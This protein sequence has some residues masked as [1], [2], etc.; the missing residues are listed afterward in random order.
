MQE[1]FKKPTIPQLIYRAYRETDDEKYMEY[2]MQLRER[3]TPEVL[4]ITK[5]LAYSR[6][7]IKRDMAGSILSQIAYKT[8]SFKGTAIHLLAKLL[9]DK[10]EDV[11]A[12][13]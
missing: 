7:P 8:K 1:K 6:D 10:H 2:I 3:G 9:N 12:S 4:E 5:K 11:I 13:A